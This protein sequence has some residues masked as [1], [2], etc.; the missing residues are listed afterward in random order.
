MSNNEL[1]KLALSAVQELYKR[2]GFQDD[3]L[4]D[5][6]INELTKAIN[7][8]SNLDANTYGF[9]PFCGQPGISRER[10][11]NGYDKCKGSHNYPS[12]NAIYYNE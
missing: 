5:R 3:Q 10:R 12:R 9:C 7:K 11:L 6:A 4:R 2:E 8:S 1:L